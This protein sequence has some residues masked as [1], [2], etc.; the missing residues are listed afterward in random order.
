MNAAFQ[1]AV[2]EL[3]TRFRYAGLNLRYHNGFIQVASE[4]LVAQEV[5]A[6][7][8][9]LV[10]DPKWKNVD[11]DIKEAIDLSVRGRWKAPSRSFLMKSTFRPERSAAL[12]TTSTI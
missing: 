5:E 2:D 9:Q 3:N 6:P 8:W 7:F 10:A 11:H 1:A 12:T 4:S